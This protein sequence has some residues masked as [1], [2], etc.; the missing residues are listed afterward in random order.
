MSLTPWLVRPPD[1][2]TDEAGS[3]AAIPAFLRPLV[4]Q[5]DE[6]TR[7]RARGDRTRA[8][9]RSLVRQPDRAHAR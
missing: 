1:Q 2:A 5:Q 9:V 7:E 4:R 8:L 3:G 6:P